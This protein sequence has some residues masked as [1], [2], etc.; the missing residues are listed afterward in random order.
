M[1]DRSRHAPGASKARQRRNDRTITRRFRAHFGRSKGAPAGKLTNPHSNP[2]RPM[3]VLTEEQA[4]AYM[5]KLL[6]AM[7]QAGGSDLFISSEFPPSMKSNGSMQPLTQ[8]KLTADV[9]RTLA[10]AMMNER[11]REEFAQEMEC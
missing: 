10:N 3:S 9:T 7:T 1:R 2:Q 5:H 4:R 8:Q 6:G 11:Q